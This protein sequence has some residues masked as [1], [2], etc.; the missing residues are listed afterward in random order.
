MTRVDF[1][2]LPDTDTAEE[3]VGQF[4]DELDLGDTAGRIEEI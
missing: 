3:L 2:L 4:I 1:Y